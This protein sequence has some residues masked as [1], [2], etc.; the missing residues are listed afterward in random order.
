MLCCFL[1]TRYVFC[2]LWPIWQHLLWGQH[3]SQSHWKTSHFHQ[4]FKRQNTHLSHKQSEKIKANLPRKSYKNSSYVCLIQ[5][6]KIQNTP[7]TFQSNVLTVY[8][9]NIKSG[10]Y[11]SI[12]FCIHIIT[13]IKQILWGFQNCLWKTS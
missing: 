6:C 2:I 11:G 8:N 1:S 7:E 3:I 12:H 9:S 5:Q 10:I 13:F 4:K